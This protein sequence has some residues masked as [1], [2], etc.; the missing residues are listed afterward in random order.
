[1]NATNN[2]VAESTTN[3]VI[4]RADETW[5]SRLTRSIAA[6]IRRYRKQRKWSAQRLSDECANLGLDFPRSTLADLENGRRRSISVAELLVVAKALQ[7][8][9]ADLL[10]PGD[11]ATW[12]QPPPVTPD[13]PT[14]DPRLTT[15][16]FHVAELSRLVEEERDA[17]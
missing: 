5:S 13:R 7:V 10:P 2:L 3:S 1:M 6:Q 11:V 4:E 9:P 8:E 14:P 12:L 17:P 15:I 16:R